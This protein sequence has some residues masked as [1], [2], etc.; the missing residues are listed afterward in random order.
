MR[1]IFKASS[2]SNDFKFSNECEITGRDSSHGITDRSRT[3]EDVHRSSSI[4]HISVW[5]SILTNCSISPQTSPSIN[6]PTFE[7]VVF[8]FRHRI[9]ASCSSIRSSHPYFKIGVLLIVECRCR[10]H[11]RAQP[12][13]CTYSPLPWRLQRISWGTQPSD[14]WLETGRM[15]RA[16]CWQISTLRRCVQLCCQLFCNVWSTGLLSSH[17]YRE[18][19]LPHPNLQEGKFTYF[20]RAKAIMRSLIYTMAQDSATIFTTQRFWCSIWYTACWFVLTRV[21]NYLLLM[22]DCK[23]VY[24]V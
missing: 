16:S 21:D 8:Y 4:P 6:D 20:L 14:D 12:P 3:V 19:G 5:Q 2:V 13:A 22:A 9:S 10:C 24:R 17:I 11:C 7:E 18:G 1:L 23:V 15:R